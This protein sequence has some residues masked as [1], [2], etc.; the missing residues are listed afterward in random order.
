MNE[1][2][3]TPDKEIGFIDRIMPFFSTFI[4]FGFIFNMEYQNDQKF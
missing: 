3:K 2:R 1:I 4:R